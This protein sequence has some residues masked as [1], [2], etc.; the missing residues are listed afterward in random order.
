MSMPTLAEA[1]AAI[2][3]GRTSSTALVAACLE[4]IAATEPTIEAWA[5]LDREHALRQAE[6]ADRRQR[7]G[8]AL[9][10]L[11]G[12]PIA[13]KDIYDTTDFP[14]E[15]GSALWEGYRPQRDA[16][17]VT[18]LR[19]AGAVI[20]GKTVTTE[21]AY[22]QPN[23]TRN[24]HNPAHTPGGSSSG[25]AAAV[26]AGM[27]PAALGSQTNGSVIRPAA[28]CG[29]VGYKPTHGTIPRTGA[30]LLSRTLDTVGVLT[31]TVGDAAF[32]V[33]L[34]AGTDGTD[35]DA[36]PERPGLTA[37]LAQPLAQPPRL[38]FVRGLAWKYI[39]PETDALFAALAQRL[40]ASDVMLSTEFD[41]GIE[42]HGAVMAVDMAT[43]FR[44]DYDRG[45]D[46]LSPALCQLLERGRQ[47]P[48]AVYRD[49]IEAREPLNRAL[50]PIFEAYDAILTPSAAGP[51]PLF[52]TTGNPAFCSLWT[53]L[54]TPSISLPLLRSAS[55]M[56]I[57]VQLV[58]R[59]GNDAHLLRVADWLSTSRS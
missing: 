59:R 25:S 52:A 49:A 22:Y 5:H 53:Y 32:L 58:G 31:R 38:A 33:E 40:G 51:A 16:A 36:R 50:D 29:V 20:P 3:E 11:H 44:A 4:R 47:V 10:P 6:S 41:N 2:R 39:E 14:T 56:P 24:P 35:P 17:V 13:V 19:H 46:K 37:A 7:E 34:L 48:D 1:M 55:G 21:Y 57:G 23:K 12:V 45:R 43:N 9:G 8:Q 15:Y 18:R 54:G 27:V 26:A 42:Q 30:M 28:F